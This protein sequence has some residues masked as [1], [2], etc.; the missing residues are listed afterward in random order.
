MQSKRVFFIVSIFWTGFCSNFADIPLRTRRRGSHGIKAEQRVGSLRGTD[1]P[2]VARH[3][4]T[5]TA[6]QMPGEK[7]FSKGRC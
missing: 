6:Q 3:P 4:N 7:G 1:L 5:P 2:P